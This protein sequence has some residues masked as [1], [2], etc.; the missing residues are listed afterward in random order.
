M[1]CEWMRS[2]MCDQFWRPSPW[3]CRE[4][5]AFEVAQISVDKSTEQAWWAAWF[6]YVA[7]LSVVGAMKISS[8]ISTGRKFR[9]RMI[10]VFPALEMA[11]WSSTERDHLYHLLGYSWYF[12]AK[13]QS[14]SGTCP[15]KSEHLLSQVT[16]TW[17]WWHWSL[18]ALMLSKIT[19]LAAQ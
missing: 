17:P 13:V 7:C 12:N 15:F 6:K 1:C 8:T 14:Q 9:I 3:I 16:A 11:Q 2:K 10:K 4:M 5:I 19:Y 18:M